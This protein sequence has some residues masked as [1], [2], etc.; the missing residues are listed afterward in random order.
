MRHA[1][2]GRT[3]NRRAYLATGAAICGLVGGCA[4]PFG[5]GDTGWRSR[6]ADLRTIAADDLRAYAISPPESVDAGVE[7]LGAR[8]EAETLSPATADELAGPERTDAP[9]SLADVRAAALV[10]N[11]DLRVERVNPRTAG[12]RVREEAAAFEAVFNGSVRWSRTDQPVALATQS[13]QNDSFNADVG[14]DIPLRTGGTLSAAVPVSRNRTS[15][16]FSL[17]NPAVSAD[18]R[19]T[20]SQP[21]LRNAG[22]QATTYGLRVAQLQS[23]RTNALSRLEAIRVLAAADRAYW[24]HYAARRNLEV[25]VQQLELA[26]VQAER[27]ERRVRAG[28]AAEVEILRAESG[29]AERVEAVIIADNQLRRARRDLKRIM[30]RPDLPLDGDTLLSPATEPSPVGLDLD[31]ERLVSLALER[32]MEMLEL[33]VQLA[34][35]RETIDLRRNQR[36]PLLTFDYTYNINGLGGTYSDA[37]EQVGRRSFDDWSVGLRGEVP[38]GNEAADSR[39]QQALLARV[40]RLATKEQRVVA[41]RQEVLDAA[42][43]LR[44]AWLRILAARREVIAASRTLDAEER[45]FEVGARTSTDVLDAQSR[46]ALARY[47][48]IQAVTDY[49]I[50]QV[51]LAFSTGSLLGLGQVDW[52]EPERTARPAAG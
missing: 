46:L 17:L 5:P 26:R 13:T 11:L 28:D 34:I 29:V 41:I 22:E 10:H 52:V 15:N 36:L 16:P 39:Y 45:Q 43:Q 18:V 7:R 6:E 20:I 50:A 23:D 21:L 2:D 25:S 40:Q 37:F 24:S 27:A 3:T 38:L 31:R 32:R 14:L 1:V 44:Q 19:F 30:G 12:E 9:V 48:E 47:R 51:D 8:L 42:D 4:S 33:E 35:D 49:E